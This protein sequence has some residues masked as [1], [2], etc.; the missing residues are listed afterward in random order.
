MTLAVGAVVAV[1]AGLLPLQFLVEATNMS[2]LW[3][4]AVVCAAVLAL[5]RDA[6]KAKRRFRCPAVPWVPLV[7]IAG[8]A[9]LAASL[10][11]LVQLTFAAWMGAGLVVYAAYG[12]RHSALRA[13]A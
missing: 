4:F 7:A 13:R 10:G 9:V 3:F 11:A 1:S 12:V 8:C 5:R 6:P 2:F